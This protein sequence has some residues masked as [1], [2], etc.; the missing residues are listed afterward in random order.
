MM[1]LL[2]SAGNLH[3]RFGYVSVLCSGEVQTP[4]AWM[5][6]GEQMLW[7]ERLFRYVGAGHRIPDAS[8]DGACAL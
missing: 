6:E 3:A 2:L 4:R 8:C 7:V 5:E 1:I